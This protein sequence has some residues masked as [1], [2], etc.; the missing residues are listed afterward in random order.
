MDTEQPEPG[1]VAEQQTDT[2]ELVQP[3]SETGVDE[4]SAPADAESEMVLVVGDE[5]EADESQEAPKWVKEVRA[6]NRELKKQVRDLQSR[7]AQVDQPNLSSEKP[8]L[9]G[10]DYDIEKHEAAILAWDAHA[11]KKADVENMEKRRKQDADDAW[12]RTLTGYTEKKA[13]LKVPGIEDAE[14]VLLENLHQVQLGMILQGAENPAMVVL[15][16]GRDTKKAKQLAKITD[17]VKFA[18]A[19]GRME[20][21]IS[22]RKRVSKAPPE[23]VPTGSSRK[24]QDTDVELNRLRTEA[25]NTGDFSKIMAYKRR[26]RQ[27]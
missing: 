21:S 4:E 15:A 19:I 8:T 6:Q 27:K 13:A 2:T 25:D 22:I 23:R 5:V 18:A 11:R 26:R 14:A 3:E 17:P 1:E 24:V 20:A 12:Q 7:S 10:A 16:I 9:E